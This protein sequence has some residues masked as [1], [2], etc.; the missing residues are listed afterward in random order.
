MWKIISFISER[1][2]NTMINPYL[3]SAFYKSPKSPNK[4]DS[5]SRSIITVESSPPKYVEKAHDMPLQIK[6][7]YNTRKE[8]LMKEIEEIRNSIRIA[9]IPDNDEKESTLLS[10]T[11]MP[12]LSS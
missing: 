12:I 7:E 3:Q 4:S 11:N 1:A 9:T 10:S 5:I 8:S 2:E 6:K